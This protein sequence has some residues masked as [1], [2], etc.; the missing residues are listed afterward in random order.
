[1]LNIA[2][3]TFAMLILGTV[4]NRSLLVND[5]LDILREEEVGLGI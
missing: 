3:H 2:Y 5:S 4:T 1:M